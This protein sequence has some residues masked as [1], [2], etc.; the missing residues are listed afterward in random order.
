M[1]I[2]DD[3]ITQITTN[4]AF[5]SNVDVSQELPFESGGSPLYEK[6]MGTIYVDEQEINVE[7]LYKTL[8]ESNVNQTT[9]TINAYLSTDAKNEFNDIDTVVAN[10][11]IARNVVNDTISSESNY[12]TEITDDVIT[13]TFEYNFITV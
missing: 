12:E 8:D 10:L 5:T 7:T 11:L 2:R 9:T 1:A 6:N 4:T 13:Y 3:L